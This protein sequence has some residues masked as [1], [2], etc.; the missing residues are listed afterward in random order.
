MMPCSFRLVCLPILIRAA[1]VFGFVQ[2]LFQVIG[3]GG[4]TIRCDGTM[5]ARGEGNELPHFGSDLQ[6]PGVHRNLADVEG[7]LQMCK[8]C[9]AEVGTPQ[10]NWKGI[11]HVTSYTCR[12][13]VTNM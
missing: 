3:G 11:L 6:E 10:C 12:C 1:M 8:L 9:R 13:F 2:V 7:I 4:P 5:L